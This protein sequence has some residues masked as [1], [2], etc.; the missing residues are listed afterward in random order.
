MRLTHH[1]SQPEAEPTKRTE[2]VPAVLPRVIAIFDDTGTVRLTVDG[3]ARP[4]G[5]SSREGLGRLLAGIADEHG[6]PVRVEVREP[7]GSRYADILQPR[8][9]EAKPETAPDD[10]APGSSPLWEGEGFM[11]GETVLVA[12]VATSTQADQD[13]PASLTDSPKPPRQPSEV[14]LLGSASG[15][16]VRASLPARPVRRWWWR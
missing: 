7:D 15:T 9:P 2:V 6:E 16:M 10:H 4:D 1:A 12:V 11:P 8:A 14:V 5:L 3:V 13:G